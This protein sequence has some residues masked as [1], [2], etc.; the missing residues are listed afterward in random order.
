MQ[1]QIALRAWRNSQGAEAHIAVFIEN[2]IYHSHRWYYIICMNTLE[3]ICKVE[4]LQEL[5]DWCGSDSAECM[6]KLFNHLFDFHIKNLQA[7]NLFMFLP[8][9]QSAKPLLKGAEAHIAC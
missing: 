1:G 7:T 3:C 2:K 4:V 8:Q 5:V 9:Q 6:I